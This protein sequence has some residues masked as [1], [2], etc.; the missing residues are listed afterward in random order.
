[1]HVIPKL[2]VYVVYTIYAFICGIPS[3]MSNVITV[4]SI[5]RWYLQMM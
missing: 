5:L 2:C 3:S 1:M 4:P